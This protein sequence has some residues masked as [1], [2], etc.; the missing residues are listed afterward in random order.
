MKS[1]EQFLEEAKKI[2]Q[3]DAP[4]PMVSTVRDL[5]LVISGVQVA[6]RH[7]QMSSYVLNN[8]QR[9]TQEWIDS[10]AEHHPDAK[11]LMEMGWQTEHDVDSE[12]VSTKEIHQAWT[13]Y[14]MNPDGTIS[15]EKFASLGR[16]QDWGDPRWMYREY[17]FI[18]S[19]AD[20]TERIVFYCH[21][22]TDVPCK[23][24][25]MTEMFSAL[26]TKSM[27]PGTPPQLCG[28][29]FLHE[30]DF[31]FE[32]WGDAPPVFETDEYW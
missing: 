8:L 17:C 25:E 12:G 20:D 31:W 24:H 28:K 23:R 21:A 29:D 19:N 2:M 27:M 30:E 9:I 26:I 1:E 11:E 3:D 32:D 16:P 10:I 5:W 18:Q 4:M 22:W 15:T 7:P 13:I 14:G 6:C